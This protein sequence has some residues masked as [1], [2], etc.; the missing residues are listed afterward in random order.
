MWKR[1][2]GVVVVVVMEARRNASR[3]SQIKLRR[4]DSFS[5]AVCTSKLILSRPGDS[6]G[7]PVSF[8][9]LSSMRLFLKLLSI[10]FNGAMR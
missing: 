8:Y 9:Y 5:P 3:V 10:E 2:G 6:L 7:P 4:Q 1:I